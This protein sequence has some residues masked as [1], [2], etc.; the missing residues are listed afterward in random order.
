MIDFL[1][2]VVERTNGW[3]IVVTFAL[4]VFYQIYIKTIE[5]RALNKSLG[6]IQNN[7]TS[8]FN[9]ISQKLDDIKNTLS[10]II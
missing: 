8:L 2:K 9:L 10:E 3:V 6:I 4:Y 7:L 1:L 5:H